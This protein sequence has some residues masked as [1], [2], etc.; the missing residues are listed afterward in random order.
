MSLAAYSNIVSRGRFARL[1]R[2]EIPATSV[3]QRFLAHEYF[4]C[5]M[6]HV[7]LKQVGVGLLGRARALQSGSKR[8]YPGVIMDAKELRAPLP[9]DRLV[10][11]VHTMCP[12][13]QRTWLTVLEKG[14]E[15]TM[16]HVDLSNKPPFYRQLNPLG[17]V[18]CA[19]FQGQVICESEDI[20]RHGPVFSILSG[21]QVVPVIH[22]CVVYSSW[23]VLVKAKGTTGLAQPLKSFLSRAF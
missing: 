2:E 17:L 20:C 9:D 19:A 11:Y 16:V 14:V 8:A 6:Q 22:T 18:P 3:A 5:M 10:I 13:A 15:H 12:Y 7:E 4:G 1:Q 21:C 23:D